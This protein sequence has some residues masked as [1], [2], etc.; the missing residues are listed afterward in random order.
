[1]AITLTPYGTGATAV[2]DSPLPSDAAAEDALQEN[3]LLAEMAPAA[4]DPTTGDEAVSDLAAE[5]ALRGLDSGAAEAAEQMLPYAYA[6]EA[7]RQRW[8]QENQAEVLPKI[9]GAVLDVEN[10][11]KGRNMAP[12]LARK[13]LVGSYLR[14][15]NGGLEFQSPLQRDLF[16][17][18]YARRHFGGEGAGSDDAFFARIGKDARGRRDRKD[19]MNTVAN[20][21]AFGV[22]ASTVGETP[23]PWEDLLATARAHPGYVPGRDDEIGE[24]FFAS[25]TRARATLN[26]GKDLRATWQAMKNG[27][28][29]P[30]LDLEDLF[31][32]EEAREDFLDNITVLIHRLPKE[33]QPSVLANFR[34]AILRDLKSQ[35]AGHGELLKGFLAP[36]TPGERYI[37]EDGHVAMRASSRMYEGA[38]GAY[39]PQN[40]EEERELLRL[41]WT[42]EDN[43]NASSP[44]SMR[45]SPPTIR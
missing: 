14:M 32:S 8:Q 41:E 19:L 12:D 15:G 39:P 31:A 5:Q 2:E 35:A 28:D 38:L 26:H 37:N 16:R 45:R 27:G 9:D 29:I 22:L 33:Q 34:K 44:T 25:H 10:F 20:E 23:Q 42:L 18:E 3:P 6:E 13:R 40:D 30:T 36:V 43:A 21:A 11:A 1:M 7:R 24:I 4:P 17:D